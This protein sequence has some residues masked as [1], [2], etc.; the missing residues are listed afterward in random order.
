MAKEVLTKLS[1]DDLAQVCGGQIYAA[2]EGNV[3]RWYVPSPP[4]NRNIYDYSYGGWFSTKI[5]AL[6]YARSN[7]LWMD[8]TP[9]ESYR[10]ARVAAAAKGVLYEIRGKVPNQMNPSKWEEQLTELIFSKKVSPFSY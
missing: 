1:D 5:G 6:N 9:C 8:I 7:G 4:C 2:T 10:Q 3:T